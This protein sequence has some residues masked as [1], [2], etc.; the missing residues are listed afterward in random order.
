MKNNYL[1]HFSLFMAMLLLPVAA[2]GQITITSDATWDNQTYSENVL[3]SGTVTITLKGESNIKGLKVAENSSLTVKSETGGKLKADYIGSVSVGS[4]ATADACG[5]ITIESCVI[6]TDHIGAGSGQNAHFG[7]SSGNGNSS[8]NVSI[9]NSIIDVKY[10]GF[11]TGGNSFDDPVISRPGG[12]SGSCSLVSI[13][14]SLITTDDFRA[15]EKSLSESL[16]NNKIENDFTLPFDWTTNSDWTLNGHSLTIPK[17]VALTVNN[18]NGTGTITGEGTLIFK[19]N[20]TKAAEI[21]VASTVSVKRYCR[22]QFNILKDGQSWEGSMFVPE[23]LLSKNAET[24]H[25]DDQWYWNRNQI[26][27]N[28]LS[29]IYTIAYDMREV[30]NSWKDKIVNPNNNTSVT[31]TDGGAINLDN[32]TVSFDL[33]GGNGNAPSESIVL[34]KVGD[35]F[36]NAKISIPEG[37]FKRDY[38]AFDGWY[39]GEILITEKVVVITAPTAFKARWTPNEIGDVTTAEVSGTYGKILAATNTFTLPQDVKTICGGIKS[40]QLKDGSSLPAGLSINSENG[41]ISGTPGSVTGSDGVKAIITLTAL[42]GATKDMEVT[43]KI[44]PME[45]TVTPDPNQA[46]FAGGQEGTITYTHTGFVDG[47]KVTFDGALSYK[48]ENGKHIITNPD[49]NGLVLQGEKAGN[50]TLSFSSSPIE[51]HI[52]SESADKLEASIVPNDAL[53][54]INGWYNELPLTLTAPTGF[55]LKEAGDANSWTISQDDSYTYHLVTGGV[56]YSHEL[57]VDTTDPAIPTAPDEGSL[58]TTTAT[59]TLSD[60]L[61]GIASY[62]VSEAGTEIATWPVTKA[63]TVG[64]PSLVYTFTGTPG[65]KHTLDFEVT[66]MA[67]NTATSSVEF[68]LKS[69]PYVPPVSSY[70]DIYLESSDSVRLSSGSTSVEEGYSFTFTAEV[71]EGYD[72]AT[73]VV[74]YKRGRSGA[75]R[76]LEADGNGKYRVRSVYDDIYVRASVRRDGDPTA[77]ENVPGGASRIW[78][79]GSRIRIGAARPVSVRVVSLGGHL[80]RSEQLPAGDSEILGLPQGVYIVLLS[81]G[82]R[83]KVMIY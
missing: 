33:N 42:N 71:A 45:V 14:K 6:E 11:G 52:Y 44:V 51:I 30:D 83:G 48:D 77:V 38:Y 66:D 37:E 63:A 74:E 43:F 53:P 21:T 78:A 70:Y 5:S 31:F 16:I 61:S 56:E 41:Q 81:D 34:T 62:T 13:T 82:S 80:V 39:N 4:D 54:N 29:G 40:Y 17:D 7:G 23:L 19:I 20:A 26:F 18:L 76:T 47:D 35:T 75:W 67:G 2:W 1:L 32:S 57:A 24:Y 79:V 60:L 58:T 49:A 3:I 65:S 69:N 36:T 25:R 8:G 46:L 64:E 59:F 73:L 22:M 15:S 12:S 50:Y 27:N 10:I 55:T 72:P 68:T 28:I 9:S